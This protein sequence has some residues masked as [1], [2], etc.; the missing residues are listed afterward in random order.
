MVDSIKW[1]MYNIQYIQSAYFLISVVAT[2]TYFFFFYI[3]ALQSA[4][5]YCSCELKSVTYSHKF[6]LTVVYHHLLLSLAIV[7]HSRLKKWGKDGQKNLFMI[8][9]CWETQRLH[10]TLVSLSNENLKIHLVPKKKK[11]KKK[12][13][14]DWHIYVFPSELYFKIHSTENFHHIHYYIWITS[15]VAF[16]LKIKLYTHDD[17]QKTNYTVD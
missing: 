1:Y 9:L 8:C 15:L 6:N 11:K 14:C 7:H 12:K 17:K 4:H 3:K 13:I 5:S 10:H 2:T 16:L